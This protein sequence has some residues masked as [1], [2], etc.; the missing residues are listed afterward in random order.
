MTPCYN[1]E[2]IGLEQVQ[3]GFFEGWPNPPSPQVHLKLLANSDHVVLAVDQELD[4]VVGFITAISDGVLA[5]YIPLLEVLPAYRGRGIGKELVRRMLDRLGGLY[6]I[7]LMCDSDVQPFYASL[8]MRPAIGMM[9]RNYEYQ[10]GRA[11]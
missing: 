2:N 10:S 1:S 3:G 9:I 8:G 11:K 7:D 4:V 6:A 5:A